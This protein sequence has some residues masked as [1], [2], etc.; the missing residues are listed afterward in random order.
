MVTFEDF[1]WIGLSCCIETLEYFVTLINFDF[2][3]C[4]LV[5]LQIVGMSIFSFLVVAFYCFLG[6][7]LGNR[8]A[9]ISVTTIYS[10]VVR[11]DNDTNYP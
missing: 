5:V 8:S 6:L 7:F 9:E 3:M 10:F 1:V 4:F 11:S 2:T